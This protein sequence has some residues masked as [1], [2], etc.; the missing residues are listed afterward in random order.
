MNNKI[1]TEMVQSFSTDNGKN[2]VISIEAKNQFPTP[3]FKGPVKKTLRNNILL[4]SKMF[5]GTLTITTNYIKIDNSKTLH[6]PKFDMGHEIELDYVLTITL[7]NGEWH[8]NYFDKE[9]NK[10]TDLEFHGF[11]YYGGN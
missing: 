8:M 7:N 9:T 2:T 11:M 6:T 5:N 4:F 3:P 10:S 1:P